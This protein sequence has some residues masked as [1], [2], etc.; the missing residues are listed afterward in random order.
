MLTVSTRVAYA[1]EM[2]AQRTLTAKKRAYHHG[3]LSGALVETAVRM[4][5]DE[6]VQALTL[7]SVAR[8]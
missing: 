6:G 1:R 4:I 3:D 7:R 8:G 2:A 5:Q